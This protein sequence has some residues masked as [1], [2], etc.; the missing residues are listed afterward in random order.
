MSQLSKD[1]GHYPSAGIKPG[2]GNRSLNWSLNERRKVMED[3]A[4]VSRNKYWSEIDPEEKCK[5]L[6]QEVNRMQRTIREVAKVVYNLADHSHA[7]NGEVLIPIHKKDG[8]DEERKVTA[9][10]DCYF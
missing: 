3:C 9:G 5:R 6:R 1:E 2:H 7:Q 8:M 4:N 10:D